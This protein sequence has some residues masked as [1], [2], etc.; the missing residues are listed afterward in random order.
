LVATTS[1]TTR[2]AI[3]ASQKT[4]L[5]RSTIH[6]AVSLPLRLVSRDLKNRVED[7]DKL[8]AYD[9]RGSVVVVVH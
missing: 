6:I 7:T 1:R 4:E 8:A 9:L 2:A 3:T 5:S